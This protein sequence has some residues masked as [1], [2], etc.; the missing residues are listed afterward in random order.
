MSVFSRLSSTS[1]VLLMALATLFL[2]FAAC[3]G[4]AVRRGAGAPSRARLGLAAWA[5]VVVAMTLVPLAGGGQ[6]VNVVPGRAVSGSLASLA[7]ILGNIALFVPLGLLGRH[8]VPALR[9]PGVVG[10]AAVISTAIEVLQ[11]FAHLG[12]AADINDVLA[13]VVGATAGATLAWWLLTSARYPADPA[14]SVREA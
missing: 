3:L 13:N 12:R 1:V 10:A 7:N 6:H 14:R 2:A 11:H 4:L 5:C 9:V 8:A